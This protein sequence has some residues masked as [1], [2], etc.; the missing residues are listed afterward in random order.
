MTIDVKLTDSYAF[1]TGPEDRALLKS[2]SSAASG[3]CTVAKAAS[4]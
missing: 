3:S 4:S 1:G 2:T